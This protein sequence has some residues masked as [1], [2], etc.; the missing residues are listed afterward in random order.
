MKKIIISLVVLLCI[1]GVCIVTC[2]DR[3]AHKDTLMALVNNKI[4]TEVNKAELGDELS[5]LGSSLGLK[6]VGNILDNR[7]EVK[8]HFVYSVGILQ[9][10]SGPQT[11]SVGVLGHV[12]TASQEKFDAYVDGQIQGFGL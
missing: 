11:V 9:K 6:L 1:A 2:P 3:H 12:F 10:E 7:L 8:N 5:L 4:N